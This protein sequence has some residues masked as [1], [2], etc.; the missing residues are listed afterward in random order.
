MASIKANTIVQI[1]YTCT[2]DKIV[3][4]DN[5]TLLNIRVLPSFVEWHG[6][7]I[8]FICVSEFDYLNML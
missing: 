4:K 6:R 3:A 7:D 2:N 5:R 8:Q 1:I